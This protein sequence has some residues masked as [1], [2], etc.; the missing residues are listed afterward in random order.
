MI[1]PSAANL[2]ATLHNVN[3][4]IRGAL[5]NGDISKEIKELKAQ[6][7]EIFALH[8]LTGP[9]VAHLQPAFNTPMFFRGFLK[10][11]KEVKQASRTV[12]FLMKHQQNL[13]A[14]KNVVSE[15]ISA[16]AVTAKVQ[17][18]IANNLV[19]TQAA[20]ES[21][22]L[23]EI[24]QHPSGVESTRRCDR[25]RPMKTLRSRS[26]DE[27]VVIG[28]HVKEASMANTTDL[29]VLPKGL[30]S[31]A[32]DADADL[33][34]HVDAVKSTLVTVATNVSTALSMAYDC[35]ESCHQLEQASAH[36]PNAGLGH[37]ITQLE[38][39]MD[40]ILEN[41]K[42]LEGQY[43]NIAEILEHL[44]ANVILNSARQLP[45]DI[46][47]KSLSAETAPIPL[48]RI[49][50]VSILTS[51]PI[52]QCTA[53]S[54]ISGPIAMSADSISAIL[55]TSV[56]N[57][58]GNATSSISGPIMSVTESAVSAPLIDSSAANLDVMADIQVGDDAAM[59]ES[60]AGSSVCKCITPAVQLI[61]PTPN[62]SQEQAAYDTTI[63]VAAT[64]QD[65]LHV[66]TGP[67]PA[68]T[69]IADQSSS[70][71]LKH[72][73]GYNM[74]PMS[75]PIDVGSDIPQVSISSIH[76]LASTSLLAPLSL[77]EYEQL[78]PRRSPCLL[79]PV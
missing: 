13:A 28:K 72:T 50:P 1:I 20:A 12:D 66:P 65:V 7:N 41:F 35:N 45:M 38:G 55:P 18:I 58:E 48:E 30:A 37:R 52:V 3:N 22:Q 23:V 9:E 59:Q 54:P 10:S 73:S 16:P 75:G 71:E 17:S 36:G 77:P 26:A 39:K 70:Q 27:D 6:L 79:S 76:L 5:T 2:L 56:P 61:P 32:D 49:T 64:P 34:A 19:A 63:I 21:N 4:C 14:F 69:T 51:A 25:G 15:P 57:S 47:T 78:S 74:S 67:S 31:K 68:V 53:T 62:N 60:I 8:A 24:Q 43:A 46:G 42:C 29:Y 44:R 33:G 11:W 40:N